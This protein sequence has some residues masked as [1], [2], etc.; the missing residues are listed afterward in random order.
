M[1]GTQVEDVNKIVYLDQ[2]DPIPQEGEVVVKIHYTGVCGSDVPRV[3][4]GAVHS[5]PQTLGHEAS[6]VVYQVGAGVDPNLIST[7]VSVLP[8]VPCGECDDCQA[9][10][11]SLCKHYSFIGSRRPGTMAEYVAIPAENIFPLGDDVSD[12]EAAFFE[13]ASIGVHGI[14][15][16][17]F[18][19]GANAIVIG[20]GTIGILTAQELLGY[21][22]SRVVVSNR[23][24]SRLEQAAHVGLKLL[25]DTSEENWQDKA[26]TLNENREFDYVFD[27]AGTPATIID[28][29]EVAANRGT[30]CFIGT[31]KSPVSFTVQQWELINRKELTVTGAW[32]SYSNPW[33]GIEW[34]KV[35]EFFDR[36]IMKID[37][38]MI[39]QIYNL[40]DI[41][42]AFERFESTRKV[43][44][45]IVIDSWQ[46]S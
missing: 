7:R 2:P 19:E 44:G 31:P 17:H 22:A 12:L 37:P 5:F 10:H 13:P 26:F 15:L 40:S 1:K 4:K 24:A 6:G 25:V 8:L 34:E 38:S 30:V 35:N 23:S 41:A 29:L 28:S 33:P 36:G 45:K 42:E 27:T 14:E 11:F 39:D 3:L 32:M 20:A 46:E 21:G 9:G 16:A 18:P 43:H